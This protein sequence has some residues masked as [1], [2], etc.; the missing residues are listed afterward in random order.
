MFFTASYFYGAPSALDPT[1]T[2][3]T[4]RDVLRFI[5]FTRNGLT[6]TGKSVLR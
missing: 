4:K 1:D 2:L 6:A 3:L 5:D